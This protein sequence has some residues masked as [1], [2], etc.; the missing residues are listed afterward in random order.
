MADQSTT[1]DPDQPS[2]TPS[3]ADIIESLVGTESRAEVIEMVNRMVGE[4]EYERIE[5]LPERAG[6]EGV[7]RIIDRL[8][9]EEDDH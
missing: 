5:R 6:D 3:D 7:R 4:T 8:V 2:P 9:G 1:N